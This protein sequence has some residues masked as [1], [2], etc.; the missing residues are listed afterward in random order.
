MTLTTSL[1]LLRSRNACAHRY[2]ALVEALG[3]NWP[4]TKRIPLAL[5]LEKNG[6]DDALWALRAV[7]KKQIRRA[8]QIGYLLACDCAEH[9]LGI[10]ED[11]R[12][13]D[14]RLRKALGVMRKFLTGTATIEE[15]DD[16]RHTIVSTTSTPPKISKDNAAVLFSMR[17]TVRAVMSATAVIT[18]ASKAACS[19]TLYARQARWFFSF[20]DMS[21]TTTNV[22]EITEV[23]DAAREAE[24]E[25]Q[26]TRF[27]Q[28]WTL[29]ASC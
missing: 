23:A 14:N 26:T 12:P 20:Y 22:I 1:K 11:F 28:I 21:K 29:T 8:E 13:I 19:A 17:D 2:N 4:D 7:P 24:L 10:W 3:P 5:I 9:I 15:L 18:G 27:I 25:W 16:I 6:L